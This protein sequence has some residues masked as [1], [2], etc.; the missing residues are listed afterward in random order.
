MGL[1]SV[2]C[3]VFG[4]SL[5]F[6]TSIKGFIGTF[7][8]LVSNFAAHWKASSTLD[9]TLDVFSCHAVG[10]MFG[11]IATTIF[12]A[13]NGLV[14]LSWSLL[15]AHVL[16][17]AI[18]ASF[19]FFGFLMLFRLVEVIIPLRVTKDDEPRGLDHSQ[20]RE[21]VLDFGKSSIGKHAA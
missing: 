20:H 16:G 19:S 1:V 3:I 15:W 5:C 13:P 12:A 4:F 21:S 7:S 11:M 9:D 6:G 10:G 14:S 2:L 8:P 17:L 18:V